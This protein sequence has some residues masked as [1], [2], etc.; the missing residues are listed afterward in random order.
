[1]A[2]RPARDSFAAM[3]DGDDLTALDATFLELEQADEGAHMHIGGAL[4]FDPL[5]G[6]GTPALEAVREHLS[7]R[8]HLL[9]R[10]RQRLSHPRTGRLS[11]PSWQED[12]GFDIDSHVRHAT[13]PAPGEDAELL[14]WVGD[15]YSHRLDRTRPLWEMVLLDGLAAGRW[16]LVWKTHHCLVDGVGSVDVA[17]L[18]LDTAPEGAPELPPAPEPAGGGPGDVIRS[19][20]PRP[21]SAVRQASGAAAAAARG[22]V[23]AALH[24]REALRESAAMI[25]LLVRDEV[26]AAP[27]SSIN[28]PIGGG[29]RMAVVRVPLADLKAIKDAFGG[30]VND[31]VLA[32]AAGGLRDLLEARGDDPPRAGLRAMVPVNVRTETQHGTLGN[33]VLSLFAHLPVAI[34]DPRERYE[35]MVRDTSRLKRSG[36]GVGAAALVSVTSLAPPVLH[37]ALARALFDSRLFNITITNVPGPREPLYALGAP[38]VEVIPLVPLFGDHAI[39]IAVVSYAGEVVFGLNADR[40]AVPDLGVLAE[41]IAGAIEELQSLV[42]ANTGA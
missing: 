29:R 1:M 26:L 42:H 8:L 3:G 16:A 10:Y 4:V 13:I 28:T 34:A 24:P 36:Q 15:F 41:G 12:P 2:L 20:V 9:P 32:A 31:V 21:P 14:E 33:R 11:W 38:M 39:G 7:S 22:A 40:A 37:S 25:D 30:K 17:H 19:W 23:H 27:R 5:P 35:A 18:L 6:D